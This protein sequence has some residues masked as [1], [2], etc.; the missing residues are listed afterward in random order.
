MDKF[1]K[2]ISASRKDISPSKNFVDN[3]MAAISPRAPT[4][5]HWFSAT[6][7]ALLTSS[8]AAVAVLVLVGTKLAEPTAKTA[9]SPGSGGSA[10]IAYNSS[11]DNATLASD[12]TAISN[13]LTSESQNLS[14][15]TGSVNDQ[16]QEISV[17][18]N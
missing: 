11:D 2:I 7:L 5:V 15:S 1:D 14:S 8:L 4:K 10:S 9:T 6:R 18:T 16:S 17:P 13:N 12:L 3:V